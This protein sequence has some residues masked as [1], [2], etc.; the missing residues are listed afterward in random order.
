MLDK[1]G[2]KEGDIF[3]IEKNGETL[4]IDGKNLDAVAARIKDKLSSSL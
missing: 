2:K 3:K 4:E 1:V